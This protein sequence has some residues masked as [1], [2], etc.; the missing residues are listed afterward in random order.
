MPVR[1]SPERTVCVVV[2]RPVVARL[3]GLTAVP[4]TRS[5]SPGWMKPPSRPLRERSRSTLMWW[6]AATPVSV[7]P[8]RTTYVRVAPE[9][10]GLADEGE[11]PP[12]RSGTVRRWPGWMKSPEERWLR[13]RRAP[14]ETR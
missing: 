7:S 4:V 9:R 3:A 8:L 5:V 13:E 2:V 11:D 1:V 14:G 6:R 12:E 10:A